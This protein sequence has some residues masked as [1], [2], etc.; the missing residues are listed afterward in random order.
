MAEILP[1]TRGPQDGL[2]SAP[3]LLSVAQEEQRAALGD[4]RESLYALRDTTARLQ[5]SV[6]GL[7]RNLAATGRELGTTRQ[8]VLSL[9]VTG[10]SL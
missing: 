10:A 6:Q 8:T 9:Q 3:R 4:F 1:L 5:D 7:R 2:Q